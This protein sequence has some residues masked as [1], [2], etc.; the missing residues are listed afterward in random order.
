MSEEKVYY[1]IYQDKECMDNNY[2]VEEFENL[3]SSIEAWAVSHLEDPENYG[4]FPVIEP[5]MM[6]EEEF[7]NL[8]EF[9]GY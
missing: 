5:V 9:Q 4:L 2:Y 1:K 6:T 8:P 3:P 7:D